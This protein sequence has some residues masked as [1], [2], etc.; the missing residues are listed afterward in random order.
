M[1]REKGDELDDEYHLEHYVVRSE[2]MR[3]VRRLCSK[4]E[5]NC[6][7][8]RYVAR[9]GGDGPDPTPRAEDALE[10]GEKKLRDREPQKAQKLFREALSQLQ[11]AHLSNHPHGSVLL[12]SLT[13]SLLTIDSEDARLAS[14]ARRSNEKPPTEPLT[15]E[16]RLGALQAAA[17]AMEAGTDGR[18]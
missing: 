9:G 13:G 16:Q 15:P 4:K 18:G 12:A 3:G 10:R 6:V 2:G 1:D 11:A 7:P 5:Y 17:T 8:R 14:W